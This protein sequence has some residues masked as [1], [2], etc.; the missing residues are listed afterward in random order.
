VGVDRRNQ[1]AVVTGASSGIGQA[2]AQALAA[3]GFHVLAGVRRDADAEQLAGQGLEPIILDI[4]DPDHV[5]AVTD[6]VGSDPSG[7]LLG[8]LVN[9]AG[10]AVNAPVEALPLAEWRRQ[11]EVNFFG[12]VAVIQALLPALISGHGCVVNV[13]S[14]GGRVVAPT[15]GAYGASK[16]ALE[17]MSDAL[18]R[19]VGRLGVRV[20]VVEPGTVATPIW[21]KGMATAD[22][23]VTQTPEDQVARYRDLV[24]AMRK[25]AETLAR[26]GISPADA[27]QVIVGAIEAR[28]PRARYLIGRDA[29]VMARVAGVLPDRIV[30][31][32]IARNLGLSRA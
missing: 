32:L 31:R 2:T 28:E 12:H 5:S 13:S 22:Q 25:Q 26:G 24:D 8:A 9:N 17:A 29:K 19:E 7:R 4:T 23:L 21:N 6:R 20:V 1:L 14:I 27:A 30:D 11:F 18:R 16:F 3:R 15:F 10:I